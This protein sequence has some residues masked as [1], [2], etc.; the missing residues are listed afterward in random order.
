MDVKGQEIAQEIV[1]WS[2]ETLVAVNKPP[3][4]LVIRGG[5]GEHPY[6]TAILEPLYGRLWVV[7]RLDRDTSGIVVLARTAAAHQML[8]T[9]F[10]EH[11][12]T[13]IYHALVRGAPP[14]EEHLINLPLRPD[15]DRRHRTIV[16]PVRG[17]SSVTH[18]TVLE[19]FA[20]CTLLQATPHTGRTHQIRAHLA[21]LD[22][23]LVGDTLYRAKSQP[24]SGENTLPPIERVALHALELTLAHP[25]TGE[26]LRLQAPYPDDLVAVLD[27][28]RTQS[29]SG[30]S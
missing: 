28:L 18:L 29:A 15:G 25:I 6:L 26:P 13:K 3:G 23:P 30:A 16:D 8:N 24:S 20:C 4:V 12:V 5:F 11:R 7:H 14:W 1:L 10:E 27:W 17:K 22:L 2:D 21:A 19:R 9:Q